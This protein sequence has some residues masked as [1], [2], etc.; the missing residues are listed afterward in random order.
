MFGRRMQ[1]LFG[2]PEGLAEDGG[3]EDDEPWGVADLHEAFL[4]QH[5]TIME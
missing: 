3:G 1:G 2:R 5:L 4:H